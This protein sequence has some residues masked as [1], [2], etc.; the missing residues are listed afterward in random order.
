MA[1]K[2]LVIDDDPG[3]LHLIESILKAEGYAVLTLSSPK[4][5]IKL[6]KNER[7]DLVMLDIL[8]PHKDGYQVCAEVKT[9]F[10]NKI[11]VVV[12]TDKPYEKELIAEA[13]KNF[14]ADDFIHKPFE[15]KEVL[16]KIKKLI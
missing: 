4:D 3:T 14:G 7:P 8:M 6:I 9:L 11:P 16:S 5:C 2:I 13:Y 15:T 12:F 1:K 10:N